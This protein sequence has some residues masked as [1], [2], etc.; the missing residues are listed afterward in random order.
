MSENLMPA[1][2]DFHVGQFAKGRVAVFIDAA[3]IYHSLKNSPWKVDFGRLHHYLKI[4]VRL[5]HLGYYTAFD[6]HNNGQ[7][8][9][10]S[11]IEKEGY[12][13]VKKE[14]KKIGKE[15]TLV[16]IKGSLD[17]ELALDAFE[18]ATRF[19]TLLLFSG[20]SDFV[21][22]VEKLRKRGI[23][24]IVVSKNGH[25]AWELIQCALY[26]KLSSLRNAIESRDED[27]R[28]SP[29]P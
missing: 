19:D 29:R 4:E 23:S 7:K 17:V 2:P 5:V 21:P 6:P 12:Q 28:H 11:Y 20:D 3:N 26:I 24:T 25:V 8:N 1:N 16:R 27:K 18:L 22:L 13:V 10:L 14:I 9:F 15:D